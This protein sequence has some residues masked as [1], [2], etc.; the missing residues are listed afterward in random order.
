MSKIPDTVEMQVRDGEEGGTTHD[1]LEM[2]RMGKHQ[3]FKRNHHSISILGLATVVTGTWL[4]MLTN[5]SFSMLNGGRAGTTWTYLATWLCTLTVAASLGEMASME[6]TSGG[7]YHWVSVFAPP[8]AQRYLSYISGWLDALGWQAFIAVAAFQAGNLILILVAESTPSYT[9]QPWHG[10]LMTVAVALF[11][12]A[13]NTFAARHLPMFEGMVLFFHFL[14][15]FAILIPLWVLAPK[16]SA[17][18]VFGTFAN[19]GGWTSTGAACI[20]GQLASSAAFIDVETQIVES[21]A[22]YPFVDAF[23]VATGSRAGAIGMTVPIIVLSIA[24]CFNA[25]AAASRQAWAFAGDRGL[26]Y[27]RMLS[28]ITTINKTPIPANAMLASLTM[29]IV[30]S[31]L[32][33]G[34][35]QAF[36]SILGLVTGAVGLTYALGMACFLWRRL[37]GDPL[38]HARWSLGRFGVPINIFALLYEMFA[39]VICFFPLFASATA[40]SMNWAIAMFAGVAVLCTIYYVVSGRKVYQGPVV[41][42]RSL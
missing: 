36:N 3:V 38:P 15:F 22:V 32:I 40:Q 4:G 12:T 29:A 8:K 6:P 5:S 19:Y 14:G 21:T 16:A 25:T 18:E 20:V 34:G 10:T 9:Q 2:S 13:F 17:S 35:S 39:T 27:S 31:L 26:P 1:L 28:K 37:Y 7:Q 33:L 11:A 42:L 23:T 24:M 41:K 30:L